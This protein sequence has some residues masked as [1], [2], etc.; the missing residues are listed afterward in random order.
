GRGQI[1][2]GGFFGG[3]RRRADVEISYKANEQ[4][5]LESAYEINHVELPAGSFTTH[6][7][8]Q[9]MLLTLSTDLYIRGLAQWNSQREVVGGNLLLGYRYKPGSDLFLV[10]NHLFDTDDSLHQLDRS[11]QLKL[12]YYWSP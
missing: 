4:V 1:A 8:S 3:T 7:A 10:Y 12:A 6:R 2:V 11:I 9:R 5:S